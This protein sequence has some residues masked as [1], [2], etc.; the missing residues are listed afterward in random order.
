MIP[1]R[2]SGA[3]KATTKAVN[4][5]LNTTTIKVPLSVSYEQP[6][7]AAQAGGEE[8]FQDGKPVCLSTSVIVALSVASVIVVVGVV[9][10]LHRRRK[11]R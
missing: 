6:A 1:T 8:Y 10:L 9:I 3:T 4:D 2:S 7:V 5:V 11:R